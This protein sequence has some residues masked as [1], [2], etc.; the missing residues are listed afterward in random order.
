MEEGDKFW[1]FVQ[2]AVSR[3]RKLRSVY[4]K[5]NDESRLF[6]IDFCHRGI[7]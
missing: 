1:F 6:F 2:D 4:S 3:A 7:S 5:I